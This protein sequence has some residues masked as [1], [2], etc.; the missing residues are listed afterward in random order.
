MNKIK[1]EDMVKVIT[2]SYK[3]ET[4]RVV[5]IITSKNRAIVEGIN[6]AK[7]HIRP[8]QD[9]PQGGI[10]EKELS[11]H[12]SNLALLSKGNIVKVGFGIDKNNKRYRINKKNGNK[13][14]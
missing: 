1:K 5:K 12:L 11:I 2:G 10:I 8:A 7:K 3:G 14:D 6:K 13:I 9:N 4:G